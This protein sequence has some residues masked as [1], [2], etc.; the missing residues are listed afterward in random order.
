MFDVVNETEEDD[1]HDDGMLQEHAFREEINN[2]KEKDNNESEQIVASDEN[3]N[4]LNEDNLD[5]MDDISANETKNKVKFEEKND[6]PIPLTSSVDKPKS[7]K[8][9]STLKVD[10]QSTMSMMS[11]E[12]DTLEKAMTKMYNPTA[13]TTKDENPVEIDSSFV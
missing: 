13:K 10:K 6:D 9:K 11:T 5:D 3:N 4:K 12:V 2:E 1:V 7:R 8:R